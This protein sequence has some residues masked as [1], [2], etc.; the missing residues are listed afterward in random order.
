MTPTAANRR[1]SVRA[2]HEDGRHA[3]VLEEASFE[4]AAVAYLEDLPG[5]AAEGDDDDDEISVIVR[6]ID[7][8]HEH[9]FR[10][11]LGKGK[12]APCG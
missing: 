5:A 6:D 9:C 2:R 1:F 7:S 3:R 4:A 11:D 8:G 10:V 12:T